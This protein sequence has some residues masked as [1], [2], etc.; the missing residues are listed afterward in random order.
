MNAFSGKALRRSTLALCMGLFSLTSFQAQSAIYWPGGGAGGNDKEAD[1]QQGY[2]D[3]QEDCRKT[4][5]EC[6][7]Q[8]SDMIAKQGY[9][10]T[11][12]NDHIINANG[13]LPGL[14]YHGNSFDRFDEDWYYVTTDKKN[15]KLTVYFLGDS[16]NYAATEGWVIKVRDL[17][18]NVIAAFDSATSGGAGVEGAPAEGGSGT[19][20]VEA[21]KITEVTLGKIGSYYITV[22]SKDDTGMLRGY[23]IGATLKN[24]D[25]VTADYEDAP[26]DTETEPNDDKKHADPLRSNVAMVGVFDRTL[27]KYDWVTTPS[28]TEYKYFYKLCSQTDPASLPSGATDCGCDIK[29]YPVTPNNPN[30]ILEVTGNNPVTYTAP[31]DTDNQLDP[32]FDADPATS[33]VE[34][35]PYVL[36]DGGTPDDPSD[37][38]FELAPADACEAKAFTTPEET[39]K[40]GKFHYDEDVYVYHSEGDEQLR[41]QIC[42][43]TE[44]NFDR[45]HLRINKDG[46]S[47][48]LLDGPIEPGQ[49][50]DM[51]AALPGDYYFVFSPEETGVDSETG[52]PEVEDLVGPY[53]IL[54]MSTQLS[55]TGGTVPTS[56]KPP[57]Q[58]KKP[59]STKK[60]ENDSDKESG[61][62]SGDLPFSIWGGLFGGD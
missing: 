53:D 29:N 28:K 7:V 50:I 1:F 20:P 18:G 19:S 9:G 37:D 4:P 23:N 35:P 24:T 38:E 43:R 31:G 5:L 42:T 41:V 61:D 13:L 44:C 11:E 22:Q 34:V 15:Q 21:A 33:D 58:P 8:L 59:E 17:R 10:E 27:I 51:G 30:F 32:I 47:I 49:V 14:F 54:L 52:D 16:G 45:V 62:G 56:S 46:T 3:G 26:F 57:E 36:D 48:V 2:D 25:Q 60:N 6:G 39:E 12:P 55:P 40:R